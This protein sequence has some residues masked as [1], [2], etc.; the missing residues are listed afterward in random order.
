MGSCRRWQN[1]AIPVPVLPLSPLGQ[2]WDGG[3]R[4]WHW[5]RF[6]A[7]ARLPVLLPLPEGEGRG[8]GR[9]RWWQ[10]ML[11]LHRS[12]NAGPRALAVATG[13]PFANAP[14]RDSPR[15]ARHFSL[16]RCMDWLR[17]FALLRAT[18]GAR[19]QRGL[20]QTRLR[21]RQ[22][23][24]L[25]RWLLRS[26]AQTDGWWKPGSPNPETRNQ[27][28]QPPNSPAAS[29]RGPQLG[30]FRHCTCAENSHTVQVHCYDFPLSSFS[31]P[32]NPSP[33]RSSTWP[34]WTSSRNSS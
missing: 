5:A 1:W 31:F 30:P 2:G 6:W 23:Q 4:R 21:L 9:Q 12:R 15:R 3:Q 19:V 16:S 32:P 18:C 24:A 20:A 22:S 29:Q 14:G 11:L 34:S 27:N 17:P 7:R 10:K 25:V 26:S 8:E 13:A 33:H 28:S